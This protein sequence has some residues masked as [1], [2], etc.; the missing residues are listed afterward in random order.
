MLR[1]LQF[2]GSL[3]ACTALVVLS[4]CVEAPEENKAKQ[5]PPVG[6][7]PRKSA[8]QPATAT[9]MQ[10]SAA[11]ATGTSTQ[12]ATAMPAANSGIM[13]TRDAGADQDLDAGP[14]AAGSGGAA[15]SAAGSGGSSGRSAAGSGA[16]GG[17]GGAGGMHAA[18]S[19]GRGGAGGQA[20]GLSE[21]CMNQLC[22]TVVDCWLLSAAD[23]SYSTCEDFLCK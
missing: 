23:C 20:G 17:T 18:G 1:R 2:V 11:A 21:A 7:K 14:S 9:G 19:G 5:P 13:I 12:V 15:G 3:A 4:G 8:E 6:S 16:R 22:F 10:T